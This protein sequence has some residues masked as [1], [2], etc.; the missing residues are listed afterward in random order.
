MEGKQNP[1]ITVNDLL[2]TFDEKVETAIAQLKATDE[3]SLTDFRGVG[4]A[5]LPSTVIGL[6]THA[7]EH[8]MRH[9]GQLIVTIKVLKAKE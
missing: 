4:R 9:L 8:T 1:E 7:A 2:V 3:K 5:K 6:L